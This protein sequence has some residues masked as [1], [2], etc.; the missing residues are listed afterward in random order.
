MQALSALSFATAII[1]M[2]WLSSCA[3]KLI[4]PAKDRFHVS[5]TQNDVQQRFDVSLHS[6]DDR[7]LCVATENWPNSLGYF[8]V[9]NSEVVLQ[10]G[11]RT[12]TPKS[13]L[14]SAYCPGGCGFHRLEPK[15][16]LEGFIAYEVFGD[17]A[18]IVV[19]EVKRLTFH[20][21]PVY[22]PAQ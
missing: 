8:S 18:P 6:D 2:A 9:E 12:M 19:A 20:V 17:P 16:E 7:P 5:I 15:G 3:P 22:C 1:A 10:I 14:S 11:N 13:P 21:V 4:R